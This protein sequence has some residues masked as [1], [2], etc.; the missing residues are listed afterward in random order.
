MENAYKPFQW[1]AQETEQTT[2]QAGASLRFASR[3]KDVSEGL[4]TILEMVS[5]D[6]FSGTEQMIDD[7]RLSALVRM[8]AV[9]AGDLSAEADSYIDWVGDRANDAK[10]I[11]EKQKEFAAQMLS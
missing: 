1:Y 7:C 3:A 9:V 2:I 5:T 10:E 8:A 11:Q 6:R 4:F